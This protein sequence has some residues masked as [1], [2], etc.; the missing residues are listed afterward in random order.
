MVCSE[1]KKKEEENRE[2]DDL[3]YLKWDYFISI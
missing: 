1:R 3:L 2:R